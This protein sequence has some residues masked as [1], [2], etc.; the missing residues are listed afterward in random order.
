MTHRAEYRVPCSDAAE[1]ETLRR[2]LSVEGDDLPDRTSVQLVV[3]GSDIVVRID[4][5]EARTL[6]AA[7]NSYLRWIQTGQAVVRLAR[8]ESFKGRASSGA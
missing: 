6:R 5:D 3:E 8:G 1:A 7:T 2:A 4:S